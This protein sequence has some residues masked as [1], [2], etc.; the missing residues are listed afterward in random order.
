VLHGDVKDALKHETYGIMGILTPYATG[1]NPVY[2]G[3]GYIPA[4]DHG[5]LGAIFGVIFFVALIAIGVPWIMM[6]G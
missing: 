1:P 6:L 4:R 5:R 3:S 2:Y